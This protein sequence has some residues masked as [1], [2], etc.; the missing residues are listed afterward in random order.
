MPPESW[1]RTKRTVKRSKKKNKKLGYA[2]NEKKCSWCRIAI[3]K[4][5]FRQKY[6]AANARDMVTAPTDD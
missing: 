3:D 4:F 5:Q 6:G 2:K 1:L